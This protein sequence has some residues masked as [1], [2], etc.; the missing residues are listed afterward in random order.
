[1]EDN[2]ETLKNKV[3]ETVGSDYNFITAL[4][5]KAENIGKTATLNLNDVELKAFYDNYI[6]EAEIL[7]RK[8]EL[9][10]EL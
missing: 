3:L 4:K 8:I 5:D 7:K 2:K 9:K 6:M 10:E 1:M